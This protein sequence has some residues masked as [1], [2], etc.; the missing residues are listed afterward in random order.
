MS[1]ANSAAALKQAVVSVSENNKSSKQAKSLRLPS[2]ISFPL[3]SYVC[4][5]VNM[6]VCLQVVIFKC[7]CRYD[8]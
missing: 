3:C 6:C 7:G 8:R 4:V 5:C 1:V 2:L